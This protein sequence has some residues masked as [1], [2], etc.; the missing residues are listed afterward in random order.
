M[1]ECQCNIATGMLSPGVFNI[2]QFL[3]ETQEMRWTVSSRSLPGGIDLANYDA[4][5][6]MQ[7]G[8]SG[9]PDEVLLSKAVNA[10]GTI[11]LVWNVG[12]WATWLKGYVKYQI[13]FRGRLVSELRVMGATDANADGVYLVNSDLA[14]GTGRYWTHK[15]RESYTIKYDATKSRWQLLNG[16]TVVGYQIIPHE[17]PHYG[18]WDSLYVSNVSAMTWRSAEAFM[19]ISESIAADESISAKYPTILRQMWLGLRNMI[20][21]SGV[22]VLDGEVTES[23]WRGS[24]APFYVDALTVASVPDGCT[25]VG[26]RLFKFVDGVFSSVDNIELGQD[27]NGK[28]R[29]YALEKVAG[30]VAFTV[31]GGNGYFVGKDATSVDDAVIRGMVDEQMSNVKVGISNVS[32]LQEALDEKAD[33]DDIGSI[34]SALD[35]INGEKV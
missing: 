26:A 8:E 30:K 20:I 16:N 9:E 6:V 24:V 3:N 18:L 28:I 25:V 29:L 5:L 2:K 33:K 7:H 1:A 23:S 14:D 11:T 21:K 15:S 10:D 35:A 4:F 31:K 13:V 32:G 12:K 17:E 22:T 34:N 27:S 19:Y